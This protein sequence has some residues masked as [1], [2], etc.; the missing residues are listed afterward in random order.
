[1]TMSPRLT[2]DADDE[3]DGLEG[4]DDTTLPGALRL[5]RGLGDARRVR[6]SIAAATPAG[7]AHT[8]LVTGSARQLREGFSALCAAFL[9]Q[10]QPQCRMRVGDDELL[11]TARG[12]ELELLANGRTNLPPLPRSQLLLEWCSA[13]NS[14]LG[15]GVG[16]LNASPRAAQVFSLDWALP[17]R[18][19][20]SGT[21]WYS[22]PGGLAEALPLDPAPRTPRDAPLSLLLAEV[23]G[24]GPL[25]PKD[26]EAQA[27]ETA[28]AYWLGGEAPREGEPMPERLARWLDG[29]RPGSHL[30]MTVGER[31]FV[32]R[33]RDRGAAI[34]ID[35]WLHT[36]PSLGSRAL[37]RERLLRFHTLAQSFAESFVVDHGEL[38]HG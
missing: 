16:R 8:L 19:Y 18:L 38:R 24:H 12:D 35:T 7:G 27:R 29:A 15:D 1:M 6:L 2:I 37:M 32:V 17:A 36:A 4:V 21:A 13:L 23:L 14:F 10:P 5:A 28:T 31:L 26:V 33:R 30:W 34:F 25:V 11:V 20:G 22:G 9:L 3:L